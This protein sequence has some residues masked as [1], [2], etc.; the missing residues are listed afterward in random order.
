[1]RTRPRQ[2]RRAAQGALGREVETGADDLS[3]GGE[4]GTGVVD[5]PCD[6][7]VADL[8][9]TVGVQ[10]EVGRLDVPVDNVLPVS[11]GEPG[12]G[13]RSDKGHALGKQRAGTGEPGKAVALD[14]FHHQEQTVLVLAEVEDTDH[15]RVVEASGRLRLQ[16]EAGG[17]AGVGA[18]GKQQFHRHRSAERFIEGP[19]DLPHRSPT[20]HVLQ[21][22]PARY[23][24]L[25]FILMP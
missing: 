24:H 15:V 19:P 6:A 11:R 8:Q 2:G 23:Q 5:E 22:I 3:G 7:E 13:L 25:C 17:G 10:Q 21:P 16:A 1:M 9:R 14:Q 4:G 20:D 18:L 12:R